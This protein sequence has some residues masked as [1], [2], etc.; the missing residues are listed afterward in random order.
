MVERSQDLSSKIAVFTTAFEL[1]RKQPDRGVTDVA[2]AA[3]APGVDVAKAVAAVFDVAKAS[4][5]TQDVAKAAAAIISDVAKASAVGAVD[6]AK[7]AAAVQDIE[8]RFG[9]SEEVAKAKA[10]V[11]DVAKASAATHDVAKAAAASAQDV[12][13]AVAVSGADVAKAVSAVQF[14]AKAPADVAVPVGPDAGL[15]DAL[16]DAFRFIARALS[17]VP[18]AERK[19]VVDTLSSALLDATASHGD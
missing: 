5:A 14:V 11:A 8:R 17:E 2:K 10:A 15:A 6:V 13:K 7:A 19:G 18:S 1:L 12:A 4:A 3:A 16:A 9:L